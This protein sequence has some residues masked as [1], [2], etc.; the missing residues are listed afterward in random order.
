MNYRDRMSSTS[1]QRAKGE[2][3]SNTSS[4]LAKTLVMH[5]ERIIHV[6]IYHCNVIDVRMLFRDHKHHL[7]NPH[8]LES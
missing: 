6:L 8:S 1:S 5:E 3:C 4:T 2:Q 7:H